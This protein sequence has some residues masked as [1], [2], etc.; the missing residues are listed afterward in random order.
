MYSTSTS[1]EDLE[2]RMNFGPVLG[3]D[4]MPLS[5]TVAVRNAVDNA[6]KNAVYLGEG[7]FSSAGQPQHRDKRF[8]PI[9]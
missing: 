1:L 8:L 5:R 9:A 7:A 2:T 3:C 4:Q 6:A